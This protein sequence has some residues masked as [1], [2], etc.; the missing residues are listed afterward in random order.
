MQSDGSLISLH[1]LKE[2]DSSKFDLFAVL[3]SEIMFLDINQATLAYP[4]LHDFDV[5]LIDCKG[6]TF[7]HLLKFIP[8]LWEVKTFLQFVQETVFY[9]LKQVHLF[10]VSTTVSKIYSL[11]KPFIKKELQEQVFFH[12]N[13]EALYDIVDKEILPNEYGGNIGTI[14]ELHKSFIERN[15]KNAS[16]LKEY[17]IFKIAK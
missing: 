12:Q 9:K 17:E 1:V 10:N 6:I 15:T 8:V 16:V 13:H 3:R 4:I 11:L 7:R 14:D 2:F 5:A